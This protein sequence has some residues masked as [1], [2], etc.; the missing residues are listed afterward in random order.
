VHSVRRQTANLQHVYAAGFAVLLFACDGGCNRKQQD[1]ERASQRAGSVLTEMDCPSGLARC[2]DG[3][4]EVSVAATVGPDRACP[5]AVRGPCAQG[6]IAPGIVLIAQPEQASPRLCRGGALRV[7]DAQAAKPA[8]PLIDID[9]L[10]QDGKVGLAGAS[11]GATRTCLRGCAQTE[12]FGETV[13]LDSAALL[14]C[15]P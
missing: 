8:A 7:A 12:L 13:D 5:F 1:P 15:A 10:C 3:V 4:V 6:C 14:L 11:S 2:E 9:Y